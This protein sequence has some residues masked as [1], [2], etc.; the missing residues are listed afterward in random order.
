MGKLSAWI[1]AK[2]PKS[3]VSATQR[4]AGRGAA[5]TTLTSMFSSLSM[6]RVRTGASS[7]RTAASPPRVLTKVTLRALWASRMVNW[8]SPLALRS[9]TME[10]S[11]FIS[12]KISLKTWSRAWAVVASRTPSRANWLRRNLPAQPEVGLQRTTGKT[13]T[14]ASRRRAT[15]SATRGPC[16]P[17]PWGW[18][19]SPS[20]RSTMYWLR[21]GSRAVSS[22]RTASWRPRSMRV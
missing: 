1:T 3:L 15:C 16:R 19:G 21:P 9:V 7:R 13:S 10:R 22:R 6:L 17:A 11:G 2:A 14:P 12:A 8:M 20:V 4:P 5:S 18:V